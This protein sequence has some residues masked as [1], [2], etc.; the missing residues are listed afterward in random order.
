MMRLWRGWQL[1]VGVLVMVL[2][3]GAVRLGCRGFSLKMSDPLYALDF[4]V[5]GMV[6]GVFFRK[7]LDAVFI[8]QSFTFQNLK[9]LKI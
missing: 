9:Y 8:A 1:S 7:V 6:Q 4:E 2:L 5:F 3:F